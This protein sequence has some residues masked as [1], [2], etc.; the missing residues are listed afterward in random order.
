MEVALVILYKYNKGD[1][2]DVESGSKINRQ[3]K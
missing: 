2:R 1:F 3:K